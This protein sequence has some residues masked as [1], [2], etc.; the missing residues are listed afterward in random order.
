MKI[1]VRRAQPKDA[2]SLGRLSAEVQALHAE[3]MPELFK[4]ANPNAFAVAGEMLDDPDTVL[5]VA[6]ADTAVVGYVY[7]E[8]IRRSE[9]RWRYAQE[10]LYLHQIGVRADY[11]EQGIGLKLLEA[12]TE[13]AEA[14]GVRTLNLDVWSFN[15]RAVV[16]FR[17]CGFSPYNERLWKQVGFAEISN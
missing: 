7:G 17:R 3:A 8:I 16:F 2:E 9:S 11:R 5:F 1:A 14:R 10:L 4:P 12:V 6:E 13:T 15:E